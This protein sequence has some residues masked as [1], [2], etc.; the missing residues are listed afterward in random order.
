MRR[1]NDGSELVYLF[2][3]VGRM[4]DAVCGGGIA[5]WRRIM[6]RKDSLRG[7][8]FGRPAEASFFV[9]T[10]FI[11]ILELASRWLI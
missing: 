8:G 1:V 2:F 3:L 9:P 11:L 7:S 10:I 5:V 6:E 4:A